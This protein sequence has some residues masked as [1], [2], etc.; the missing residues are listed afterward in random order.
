MNSGN[1]TYEHFNAMGKFVDKKLQDLGGKRVHV[2]GSG[3][4]DANLGNKAINKQN[5]RYIVKTADKGKY[6]GFYYLNVRRNFI[7]Y[8]FYTIRF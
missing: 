3:D 1:K 7:M 6:C 8:Y 5:D 4:D 2:L